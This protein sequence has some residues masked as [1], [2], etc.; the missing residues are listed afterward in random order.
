M[1]M[2]SRT[3]VIITTAL[4]TVM[5]IAISGELSFFTPSNATTERNGNMM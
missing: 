2:G 3:L 5:M 1:G 4:L